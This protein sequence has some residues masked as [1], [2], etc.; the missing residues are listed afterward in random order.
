MKYRIVPVTDPYPGFAIESFRR[1]FGAAS[2]QWH[3][4]D[5]PTLATRAKAERELREFRA[6]DRELARDE[7]SERFLL[8]E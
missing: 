8:G 7:N 2:P 3:R 6:A 1:R 5:W 4:V